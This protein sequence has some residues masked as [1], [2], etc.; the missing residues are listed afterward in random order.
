MPD[1]LI[2]RLEREGK[3]RKQRVGFVQVE[4]LLKDAILDLEEARRIQAIAERAIY[5][6]AYTGMLKAGR[7][8]LL[9]NGYVPDD[10]AQHKTV[11]EL[12]SAILGE[13]FR[14]STEQFERMRRKRNDLTY[15]GGTLLSRTEAQNALSSASSFLQNILKKVKAQNP[16]LELTFE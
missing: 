15:Q 14:D 9:L 16:Q 7:A 4:V 3:I 10:G 2:R 6:L 1:R 8:L 11:V 5:L 12:T 13:K